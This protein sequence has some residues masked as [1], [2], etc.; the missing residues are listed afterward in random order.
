MSH[1]T[2]HRTSAPNDRRTL[3]ARLPDRH[4]GGAG[5]SFPNTMTRPALVGWAIE[6]EQPRIPKVGE[7]D[8]GHERLELAHLRSEFG[9]RLAGLAL[10]CLG[11]VRE[12][13]DFD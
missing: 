1:R 12:V 4:V 9:G 10:S 8:V 2:A 11:L 3:P 7:L 13:G 6:S 5:A